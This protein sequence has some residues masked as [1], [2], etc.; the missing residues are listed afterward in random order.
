MTAATSLATSNPFFRSNIISSFLRCGL[1][2]NLSLPGNAEEGGAG[3]SLALLNFLYGIFQQGDPPN[4]FSNVLL[5]RFEVGHNLLL[6][7]V[8][9][10]DEAL[11]AFDVDELLVPLMLVRFAPETTGTPALRPATFMIH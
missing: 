10:I 3:F 1:S 4:Q 11:E 7:Q 2:R 6:I 9:K 5:Y 8:F